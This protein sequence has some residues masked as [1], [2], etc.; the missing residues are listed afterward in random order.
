MAMGFPDGMT[1]W[2]GSFA[3]LKEIAGLAEVDTEITDIDFS[4]GVRGLHGSEKGMQ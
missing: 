1:G 4:R 3:G 2:G